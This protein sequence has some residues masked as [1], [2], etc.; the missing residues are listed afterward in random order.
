MRSSAHKISSSFTRLS[1]NEDG[2]KENDARL[3]N[4]DLNQVEVFPSDTDHMVDVV[5][6]GQRNRL[7]S[8]PESLCLS[9]DGTSVNTLEDSPESKSPSP[10]NDSQRRSAGNERAL[11]ITDRLHL[12]TTQS[13]RSKLNANQN[14]GILNVRSSLAR[15]HPQI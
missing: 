14:S 4:A 9:I 1:N 10:M 12:F 15:T 2:A 5:R 6:E 7:D 13:L 8:D 3:E 11:S